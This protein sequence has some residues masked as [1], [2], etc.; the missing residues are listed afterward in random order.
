MSQSVPIR[1][2]RGTLLA[3]ADWHRARELGN[4]LFELPRP[5]AHRSLKA[6]D[7]FAQSLSEQGRDRRKR[8]QRLHERLV[9][10]G[11]E[12]SDRAEGIASAN[13]KLAPLERSTTDSHQVLT[14]LLAEWPDGGADALRAVVRNIEATESALDALNTYARG[15]LLAAK[16]QGALRAEVQ[17][18]L[19]GLHERLAAADAGQPLSRDWVEQWNGTAQALIQRL[20]A[21]PAEPTAPEGGGQ[22]PAVTPKPGPEKPTPEPASTGWVHSPH[23]LCEGRV[24]PRD[25]VAVE[26]FVAEVKRTLTGLGDEHVKVALVRVE[27][28]AK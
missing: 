24:H 10:L 21:Q 14:A 28:D 18:H 5:A 1:L 17:A 2:Q 27:A 15:H 26:A 9:G 11:A 23:M 19:D 3:T 16:G 7:A 22:K 6:Q 4:E 13:A 20:L 8:L 12:E 25:A